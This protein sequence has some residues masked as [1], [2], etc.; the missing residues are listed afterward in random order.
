MSRRTATVI[1]FPQRGDP[2]TWAASAAETRIDAMLR[3]I[4]QDA[5]VFSAGFVVGMAVAVAMAVM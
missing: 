3:E 1:Q 2:D 4:A 5:L